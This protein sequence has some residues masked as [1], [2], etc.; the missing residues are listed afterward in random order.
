MAL[1]D[2]QWYI[3]RSNT[4][5]SNWNTRRDKFLK[6]Y[7]T[8][9]LKDVL[10]QEG[11]ESVVTNDPRTGYNLA[12]HL[13]TTMTITDRIPSEGLDNIHLPGITYLEEFATRHWQLTERRY[14][15]KGRQGFNDLLF[16][17]MLATGWYSVYSVVTDKSIVTDVLP[18]G[19]VY[20]DYGP[21]ELTEVVHIYP[22]SSSAANLK[23]RKNGWEL[24]RAF[25]TTIYCYDH[26]MFDTDGDVAHCTI[27]DTQ[28]VI[29]PQKMPDLSKV[30][31]LPYF[32]GPVGGLP[33]MGNITTGK[34]WQ[35]HFGEALI[36]TNDDLNLQYNKMRTYAQQA[37]RTAAQP[38]WLELSSGQGSPIAT[39]ASMSR[40]GSILR[41]QTGESV[42]ALSPPP[43]PVEL[44]NILF[45]YQNE[46]QRGLFPAAV[47]GN[48]QQQMSYL[49]MAN[50]ASASMQVLTPYLNGAIGL[51]SDLN[52][53]HFDMVKANNYHPNKFKM[54][55]NL[56]D[57]R[58]DYLFDVDANVEIPGHL[59]QRATVAR[60]LN[61]KFRLPESFLKDKLFPEIKNPLQSAADVRAEDA[62]NHPKAILVNQI[63]AYRQQARDLEAVNDVATAE[64]YKKLAASLEAELSPAAPPPQTGGNGQFNLGPDD[65]PSQEALPQELTNPL[66]S[67]IGRQS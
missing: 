13:L 43:I 33:D 61:P 60:M 41:G 16:A 24:K 12:K 27:M 62:M 49:A 36:A 10:E 20:P 21:D 11:M 22:L 34:E 32:V 59:I 56:P 58:D 66:G 40:W 65:R 67:D 57:E 38:H 52:N 30:H 37:A 29:Q 42:T 7:Q 1:G 48:T 63:I 18:P 2:V 45:N 23:C 47:F 15:N 55:E 46:L 25:T 51:R 14:R 54:P 9:T 4:L 31:R 28:F 17:W 6:W 26:Y 53:Y 44:T 39:E 8:L 19:E 3:S 35:E 5:K 50:I 64:L